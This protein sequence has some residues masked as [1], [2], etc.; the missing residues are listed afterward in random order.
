MAKHK[1]EYHRAQILR[2][3]AYIR[4]NLGEPLSL[5]AIAKQAG[6]STFHFA[7]LFLAHTGETPFAFLRRIRLMKAL[8]L[9]QAKGHTLVTEIALT[10]GYETSSAFNKAF[11]EVI[12]INPGEFRKSGKEIKARLIHHVNR[13]PMHDQVSVNL[14]PEFDFVSRPLSHYVFLQKQGSFAEVAPP[15]WIELFPELVAIRQTQII[16]YLGLSL[17]NEINAAEEAMIYQAGVVI[18]CA[19]RGPTKPLQYKEI[20]AGRYARFT[21]QGPYFQ[22]WPA[23]HLIF[24]RLTEEDVRLRAGFCIENYLNDPKTTLDKDLITELLIPVD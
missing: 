10:V 2:A 13:P 1:A 17:V 16:G 6:S 4:N 12:G 20:P 23:F 8:E 15:A 9:L 22:I 5:S 21:L 3:Q 19:P 14:S 18:S 7:R 24:M 11:K